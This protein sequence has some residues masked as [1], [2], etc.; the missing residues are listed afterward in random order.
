MIEK[1]TNVFLA[2]DTLTDPISTLTRLIQALGGII[3]LYILF[4][5]INI[6][7]NWKRIKELKKLRNDF[8]EIKRMLSK[9]EKKK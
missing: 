2:V 9:R 5:I 3:V 6:V 1:I 8:K 4:G 7:I